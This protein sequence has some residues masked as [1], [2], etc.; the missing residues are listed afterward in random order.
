M[1]GRAAVR[2]PDNEMRGIDM[3]RTLSVLGAAALALAA[4][5]APDG[6]RT[7]ATPPSGGDALITGTNYHA[8]GNIPCAMTAGQ[9]TGC[10][11]FGDPRRERVRHRYGDEA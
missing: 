9:P 1:S 2:K 5:A 11:P 6:E 3:I 8:T 4:C 7:P 10:C